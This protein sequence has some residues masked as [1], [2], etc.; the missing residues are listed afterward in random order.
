[1]VD[2]LAGTLAVAAI[3]MTF[4]AYIGYY[5]TDDFWGIALGIAVSNALLITQK[6]L[7]WS[8]GKKVAGL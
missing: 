2:A 5:L 8:I 6:N 7:L 3:V 1:V 4:S